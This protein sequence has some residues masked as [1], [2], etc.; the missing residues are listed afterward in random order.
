MVQ[1]ALTI[2]LEDM[3]RITA[4]VEKS[5]DKGVQWRGVCEHVHAYQLVELLLPVVREH[6]FELSLDLNLDDDDGDDIILIDSPEAIIKEMNQCD[7]EWLLVHK[8]GEPSEN[9][10]Y[11]FMVYGN[12]AD[13]PESGRGEMMADWG[14]LE[15]WYRV[16]D[17]VVDDFVN[18]VYINKA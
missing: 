18:D 16:F 10:F 1:K 11:V 13:D 3:A 8:P 2:P 5:H 14:G 12:N 7:E 4:K 15:A 6:G 17:P 9:V